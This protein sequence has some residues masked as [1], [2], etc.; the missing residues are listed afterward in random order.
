MS[1]KQK[2]LFRKK[3]LK[4]SLI[5]ISISWIFRSNFALFKK[6]CNSLINSRKKKRFKLLRQSLKRRNSSVIQKKENEKWKMT[7]YI[8]KKNIIF[9][10]MFY[11]ENCSNK[12]TMIFMQKHFEY[13]NFL[14]Y[15]EENIDDRTCQKTLKNTLSRA[16]N[17]RWQSRLNINFMNYFNYYRFSWNFKKNWTMNF[18]IDLS[19]NKRNKQIYD[20]ILIII[21]RYTKYFKYISARK[22]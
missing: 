3:R 11:E 17:V 9:S 4:K 1:K 20:F 12:I 6:S 2:I 7:F 14:S 18:M 5:K 15:F 16:Q 10:R 21:N 8:S 19:L 22:D 13:K